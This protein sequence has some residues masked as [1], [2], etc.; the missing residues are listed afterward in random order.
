[1][2]P[3]VA[4]ALARKANVTAPEF[5]TPPEHR[6]PS[7]AAEP[8]VETLYRNDDVSAA[9][10]ELR[11]KVTDAPAVALTEQE[12]VEGMLV[13]SPKSLFVLMSK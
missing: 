7:V 12:I 10:P 3:V 8:K 4:A 9:A 13:R 2:L 6:A 11:V 1:M 5:A